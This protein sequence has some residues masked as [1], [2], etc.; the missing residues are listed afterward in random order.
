MTAKSRNVVA[1]ALAAL[2]VVAGLLTVAFVYAI[3]RET[4]PSTGHWFD[5][6]IDGLT[7]GALGLALAAVLA[8]VA[9]IVGR[10]RSLRIGAR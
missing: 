1:S 6:A 3:V 4:G 2:A 8:A 7:Q 9:L 5:G 10:A